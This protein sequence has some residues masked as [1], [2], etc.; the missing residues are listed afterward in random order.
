MCVC[1]CR[2]GRGAW[3]DFLKR[4]HKTHALR[5]L[6]SASEEKAKGLLTAN[7][8]SLFPKGPGVAPVLGY[9]LRSDRPTT[10]TTTTFRGCIVNRG[11]FLRSRR[12]LNIEIKLDRP[13]TKSVQY[14]STYAIKVH[15][16][17]F[18]FMTIEIAI[19]IRK[20]EKGAKRPIKETDV[21][22]N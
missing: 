17:F 13:V 11:K 19:L 15:Y 5:Y 14:I 20:K 8:F 3:K 4:A 9:L 6:L 10:T 2:R 22:G 1:V 21:T 16:F 18:L 12:L 7:V